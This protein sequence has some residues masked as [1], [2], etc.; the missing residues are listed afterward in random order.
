[1]DLMVKSDLMEKITSLA[2]RRG[3]IYPGSEIYGGLANTYDYGPLGVELLRNIKNLWW[4]FFVTRRDDIYGLDTNILMNPKV[5]EASGHTASFTDMVLDCKECKTRTRADHLIEDHFSKKGTEKKVEGLSESEL[6]NLIDKE[7]ISCPA[8]GK[9]NWT[10]PRKFNLL[11]ETHIGIVSG[12]K[13]LAYLRGEIAQGMFVNFKNVLNS[14]SPK[15]PFGLAQSGAA[16]RNEIT[17]GKLTYR[18]LQF[19]LSEFEYF[20]DPEKE[21]WEK[22]F[23]YWEREMWKWTTEVLGIDKKNLRWRT[24]T[25]EERSHYSLLTKDVEYNY[26][27][28]FK[29]L[30]GLAYRTD[31]DLK[32]HMEKSGIDLRYTDDSGRKFIPHVIE[33]T[34][35]MDRSLLAVLFNS[36]FEEG[37]DSKRGV[38]LK[39]KPALAPYKVAVFPLLANKEKLVK[40]ARTIFEK[41]EMH[42]NTAWDDR[43]NIGKRYFAQDEI[44]TPWCVTVD[45]QTLDDDTVTVRDR[46]TTKQERISVDKLQ[47]YFQNK[48]SL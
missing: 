43:G 48:L 15:L 39:L 36:Y 32:N 21:K 18:T 33:P 35:G 45:F 17:L 3:F 30:Y 47:E 44:G 6:E 19:N 11:F 34:F 14:I 10:K 9:R 37:K 38:I 28:G 24:H 29:E 41:L 46:D 22:L 12:E 8:C 1:M 2:K 13:S 4:E 23:G 20:F 25:D 26:P 16:F 42:F 27:W 5:W 7:K 40:K 31:F